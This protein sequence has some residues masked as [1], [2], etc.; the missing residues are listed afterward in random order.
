MIAIDLNKKHADIKPVQQI[1]FTGN[2]GHPRNT[3]KFFI[4]DEEREIILDFSQGTVRV[5]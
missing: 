3:T 2:L 4:I 5:L 1:N